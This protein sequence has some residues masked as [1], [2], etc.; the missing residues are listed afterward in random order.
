MVMQPL[1]L[2]HTHA[3]PLQCS[4][5]IGLRTQPLHSIMLQEKA[6]LYSYLSSSIQQSTSLEGEEYDRS[7]DQMWLQCSGDFEENREC[8]PWF[9]HDVFLGW[10]YCLLPKLYLVLDT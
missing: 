7:K 5:F 2:C 4:G 8:H 9:L 6:S 1:A 10:V 3:A